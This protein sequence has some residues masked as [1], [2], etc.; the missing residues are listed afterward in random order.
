M[1][2]PCSSRSAGVNGAYSL[3]ALSCFFG[4]DLERTLEANWERAV[5]YEETNPI[6]PLR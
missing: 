5:G 4:I 3:S 2:T 6:E 1:V